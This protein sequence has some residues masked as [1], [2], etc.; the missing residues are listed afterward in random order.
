MWYV[1]F[2][3]G[4]DIFTWIVGSNDIAFGLSVGNKF[5]SMLKCSNQTKQKTTTTLRKYFAVVANFMQPQSINFLMNFNS[6]L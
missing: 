4:T 5:F 2:D 1:V 6:N 3:F